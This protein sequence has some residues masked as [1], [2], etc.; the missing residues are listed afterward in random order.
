MEMLKVSKKLSRLEWMSQA[1]ADNHKTLR[2]GYN[3]S[4]I[5]DDISL[6]TR[7]DNIIMDSIR[8]HSAPIRTR[9]WSQRYD[10][11]CGIEIKDIN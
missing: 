10:E 8:W 11:Y 1:V 2:D 3:Y 5:M 4:K 9:M 6:E 7:V